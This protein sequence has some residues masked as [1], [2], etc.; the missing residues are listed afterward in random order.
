M[1]TN[2]WNLSGL[3]PLIYRQGE[4]L[5]SDLG[6][7][8]N[9]GI[10]SRGLPCRCKYFL[11]V[12]IDINL[13]IWRLNL[14]SWHPRVLF[15]CSLHFVFSVWIIELY[16]WAAVSNIFIYISAGIFYHKIS[17][18]LSYFKGKSAL[19]L[20]FSLFIQFLSYKFWRDGKEHRWDAT[21]DPPF[22][23]V[24]YLQTDPKMI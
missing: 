24:A 16:L 5:S 2:T 8:G 7:Q 15:H 10:P 20:F 17:M 9:A 22:W 13:S 21:S 12:N 18:F 23:S 11:W 14:S 1:V 6:I 19:L 4:L 3:L